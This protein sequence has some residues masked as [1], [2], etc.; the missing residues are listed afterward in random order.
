MNSKFYS[1]Y[2]CSKK[3]LYSISKELLDFVSEQLCLALRN[4]SL[5]HITIKMIFRQKCL[6]NLD[7]LGASIL[8]GFY[9]LIALQL[10]TLFYFTSSK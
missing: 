1:F 4:L 9:D 5:H 6:G 2:P 7:F 10:S 3:C 8:V